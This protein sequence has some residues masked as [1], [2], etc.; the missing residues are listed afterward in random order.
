MTPTTTTTA[1]TEA[2]PKRFNDAV[3]IQHGACNPAGV[4]RSL[5][6]AID[7]AR[8][9]NIAPRQDAACKLICHQLVHILGM[10]SIDL[11]PD[12]QY[13]AAMK[14]AC[15]KADRSVVGVCGMTHYLPATTP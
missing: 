13:T 14:E 4:A 3:F 2:A 5:V 12:D 1:V 9:E 8:A 10:S 11:L 6:Q 7:E 15:T